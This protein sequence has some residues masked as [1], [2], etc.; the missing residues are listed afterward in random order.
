M[1][2]IP[3]NSKV[4]LYSNIYINEGETIPFK[5]VA[6]RDAYFALHRE[7]ST[8]LSSR[9]FSY[10]RKSGNIKL[11]LSA[12]KVEKCNY[13]MFVNPDFENIK[14][15]CR[16]I[17]WEYVSNKVTN[18]NYAIDTLM[19]YYNKYTVSACL[20]E[21]EGLSEE[22]YQMSV[23][24]PYSPNIYE[25]STNEVIDMNEQLEPLYVNNG[26]WMG[27][28]PGQITDPTQI[29]TMIHPFDW[30]YITYPPKEN[31]DSSIVFFIS[32]FDKS[33]IGTT[34]KFLSYFDQYVTSDGKVYSSDGTFVEKKAISVPRAYGIYKLSNMNNINKVVNWLAA[35]GLEGSGSSISDVV[36]GVSVVSDWQWD[37]YIK[38]DSRKTLFKFV[39]RSIDVQ[40]KKLLRFPF[41]YFRVRNFE[42]D[43]KEYKYEDFI[44]LANGDGYA[45]FRYIPMFDNVPM[46][47]LVPI[48]YKIAGSNEEERIDNKNF[49]QVGYASDAY[50][51]Y[52]AN[53]LNSNLIDNTGTYKDALITKLNEYSQNFNPNEVVGK[54]YHYGNMTTEDFKEFWSDTVKS[55][56]FVA[57]ENPAF[58]AALLRGDSAGMLNAPTF[59]YKKAASEWRAGDNTLASEKLAAAKPA[60]VAYNYKPGS[61]DGVL[62]L[63]L[64]SNDHQPGS[65]RFERV[66][67]RANVLSIFD[68]YFTLY[69]YTSG[70]IGIP[71]V[72]NYMMGKSE[73][74]CH[75][76]TYGEFKITY[77]KTDNIHVE[78]TKS[79][80]ARTIESMFNSGIRF[81]IPPDMPEV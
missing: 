13:L 66:M 81:V 4:E 49:P 57:N 26:E 39:P 7:Y 48:H 31:N 38:D 71:R 32:D 2:K 51:A 30:D 29:M 52:V 46:A 50:L 58:S 20:I 12:D 27:Y 35:N 18:I 59:N 54:D 45:S 75:F 1:S 62:G 77:V 55:S 17:D 43:V 23:E 40:N 42:G 79:S 5:S 56:A 15:Y 36:I 21:R 3:Q 16:I 60:F 25:F 24:N 22:G 78:Y 37:A 28:D 41:S 67:P 11:E 70:R 65:F 9:K 44:T 63:Y 34:D 10:L 74:I 69:G 47:S 72:I 14:Y 33:A 80:V 6:Q 68:R 73:D 76:N 64:K 19:T 61:T 8:E 53:R